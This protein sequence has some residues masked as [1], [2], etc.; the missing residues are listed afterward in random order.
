VDLDHDNTDYQGR[1]GDAGSFLSNKQMAKVLS[2]IYNDAGKTLEN[3]IMCGIVDKPDGTSSL[4]RCEAVV[5]FP[6][7]TPRLFSAKARD[8]FRR[9]VFEKALVKRWNSRALLFE[10]S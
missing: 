9:C 5:R 4:W 1:L 2:E 10:S 3:P 8:C 6:E 7:G